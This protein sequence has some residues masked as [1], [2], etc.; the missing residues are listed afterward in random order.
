MQ[1]WLFTMRVADDNNPSLPKLKELFL[2]HSGCVSSSENGG[3]P[4]GFT[5]GN[6]VASRKIKRDLILIDFLKVSKEAILRD[7][8]STFEE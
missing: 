6:T 8:F 4:Q 5:G 2:R 3:V 7:M 1:F